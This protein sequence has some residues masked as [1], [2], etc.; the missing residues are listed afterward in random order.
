MAD[1]PTPEVPPAPDYSADQVGEE[2]VPEPRAFKLKKRPPTS[3]NRQKPFTRRRVVRIVNLF[4]ALVITGFVVIY[5]WGVTEFNAA[6]PSTVPVTLNLPR[7]TS[8]RGISEQLHDA[9]VLRYA[10]VFNLA[11]RVR[12]KARALKAGEYVLPAAISPKGIME[13]LI[14]GGTVVHRITIAEGLQ[15]AQILDLIASTQNLDGAILAESQEPPVEG[16]LLPETYHFELG[17][18]RSDLIARMQQDMKSAVTDAWGARASGLPF[19][20]PEE[21]VILASIVEKETSLAS[22]RAHIAGV[23]INRLRRGMRLQS[24]PTVGFGLSPDAPLGRPLRRSDLKTDHPFNTYVHKGLPPSPICNPGRAAIE[25]VLHPMATKD[26]YFVADG[27][28]GHVFAPTLA[29]HNSNV[30]KWRKLERAR[31]AK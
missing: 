14:E 11:V 13:M 20:T 12:Q 10:E 19:D 18:S 5:A 25:A 9:G 21:A 16:S 26:L 30:A 31:K 4:L 8:L 7:G 29:E 22:E 17:E 1:E 28:G 6:G 27:T 24:D 15:I 2:P 23:F 3:T